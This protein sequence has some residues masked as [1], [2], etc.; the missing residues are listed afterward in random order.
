[1]E[2]C[3]E[4][5]K[6]LPCSTRSMGAGECRLPYGALVYQVNKKG[7]NGHSTGIYDVS[8]Q[9]S[10]PRSVVHLLKVRGRLRRPIHVHDVVAVVRDALYHC[11]SSA[12]YPTK[13]RLAI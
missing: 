9:P 4:Q 10:P 12:Q 11:P 7:L 2:L 6:V 3:I 13:S 8:D 5:V 1:M